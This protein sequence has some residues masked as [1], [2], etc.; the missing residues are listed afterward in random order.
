MGVGEGLWKQSINYRN[1]M[2]SGEL[3]WWISGIFMCEVIPGS[4]KN[5]SRIYE[6]YS[7]VV[8]SSSK[9]EFV[10]MALS[11][12]ECWKTTYDTHSTWTMI[13]KIIGG[14]MM[15]EFCKYET[16]AILQNSFRK[17]HENSN[18]I[19]IVLYTRQ[20]LRNFII[21]LIKFLQNLVLQY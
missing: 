7:Q 11:Y 13:S 15:N 10:N 9:I 14:M 4:K 20:C 19:K 12:C 6:L 8:Q 2:L 17:I 5:Y 1:S 3:F 21:S 16:E 18:F